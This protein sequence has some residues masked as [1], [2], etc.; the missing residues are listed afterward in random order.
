MKIYV[1]SDI[2]GEFNKLKALM[3]QVFPEKGDKLVF[4]GDYIDRGDMTFEVIEFLIDIDK[5]HDCVFLQGNHEEMFM[6]YLA[7]IYEKLFISNGGNKTVKSYGKHGWELDRLN[8]I[9][10]R[11]MPPEHIEFFK[12]QPKYYETEDYIFVHAGIHPGTPL[13]N[14]PDETLLWDRAF[15]HMD[16]E[17]KVVVFGHSP[18]AEVLDEECKICIDTGACFDSLGMGHLT[19]VQLPDRNFIKQGWTLEDIDYGD[20]N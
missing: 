2:H 14:T 4:L 8:R 9:E 17:G 13:E 5:K 18:S 3:E 11:F 7:G 15:I 6:D 20:N 10:G 19:C 16:Y 12:N 1:F